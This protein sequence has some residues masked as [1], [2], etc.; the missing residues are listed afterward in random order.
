MTIYVAALLYMQS[1][2]HS[3]LSTSVVPTL[4]NKSKMCC[5][6]TNIGLSKYFLIT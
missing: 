6:A 2:I 3:I 5:M 1:A 4:P